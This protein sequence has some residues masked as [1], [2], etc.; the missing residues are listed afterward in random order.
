MNR[1]ARPIALSLAFALAFLVVAV[2]ALAGPRN[3]PPRNNPNP[4]PAPSGPD[5]WS[6][7]VREAYSELTGALF[8]PDSPE[9]DQDLLALVNRTVDFEEMTRRAFGEP[10]PAPGCVDHWAELTSD[11]R[12]EVIS[13]MQA[14]VTSEAME[15]IKRALAYDIEIQPAVV[16]NGDARV[17]VVP[18][19]KGS[20]GPGPG[21]IGLFFLA[22]RSPPYRIVDAN[23]FK[24][25]VSVEEYRE[26]DRLL[27]T[28]GEGYAALVRALRLK[29]RPSEGPRDA[30][31]SPP[32]AAA[33]AGDEADDEPAEAPPPPPPPEKPKDSGLP[34][35]KLVLGA[36]VLLAIGVAVGRAAR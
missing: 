9:R 33:E 26:V 7:A 10:C 8:A 4:A 32:D 34:W 23:I 31:A 30:S 36:I 28:P 5:P 16:H 12:I 15:G 20:A 25:R 24:R 13:L 14:G 35:G 11:Q 3:K 6:P 27:S 1:R 2:G 22:N 21:V 29:A 18:K 17:R 19:E